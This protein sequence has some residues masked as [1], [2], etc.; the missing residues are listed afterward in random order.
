MN[1]I[2]AA[3][4][5]AAETER[6]VPPVSSGVGPVGMFRVRKAITVSELVRNLLAAV[7]SES[8][9]INIVGTDIVVHRPETISV[10]ITKLRK[11]EF[12]PD[13][14]STWPSCGLVCLLTSARSRS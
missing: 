12:T 5:E 13:F 3:F 9:V 10:K 7:Q 1:P 2:A 4:F 6:V 8:S 11:Y 14:R